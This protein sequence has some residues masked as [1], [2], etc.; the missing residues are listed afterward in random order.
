MSEEGRAVTR[1]QFEE[2]L[3]GKRTDPD[4]RDDVTP[5]L[6]PGFSWDFDSA[7]EAVSRT[8]VVR[9]PGDPWRGSED[10]EAMQSA[11]KT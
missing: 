3:A 11:R 9:L 7:M 8:L 6:R 2:N 5:L 1:A 4:F 10:A